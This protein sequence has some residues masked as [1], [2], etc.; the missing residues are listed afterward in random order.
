M[1]R[2][3]SWQRQ[4]LMHSKLKIPDSWRPGWKAKAC[5]S[6]A[7]YLKVFK[8]HLDY[9]RH[10]RVLWPSRKH[11]LL[12]SL[13]TSPFF[14]PIYK[15][16]FSLFS[17]FYFI[18]AVVNDIN[19][20]K[21]KNLESWILCLKRFQTRM[22]IFLICILIKQ[23]KHVCDKQLYLITH[24]TKQTSN[25]NYLLLT[26]NVTKQFLKNPKQKMPFFFWI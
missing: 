9:L 6:F 17:P 19:S 25:L 10:V 3:K 4:A 8:N 2:D 13:R 18:L 26:L 20:A 24:F 16:M 22:Q 7:L 15:T 21:I 14:S 5:T 11:L 23:Q 12:W 1:W